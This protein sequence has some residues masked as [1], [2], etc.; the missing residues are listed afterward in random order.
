MYS[1]IKHKVND[2]A[3]PL[4]DRAAKS[5]KTN[6]NN[7]FPQEKKIKQKRLNKIDSWQFP[8]FSVLREE[9]L[10]IINQHAVI[11]RYKKKDFIYLP[12]DEGKDVYF[13]KRGAVEIGYLEE[14]GRELTLDILS[15]GE[16]FGS[17]FGMEFSDGYAR[18]LDDVELYVIGKN[19]FDDF[20]QE[21]SLLTYKLL[22]FLTLKI[23]ILKDRLQILVF[24]NVKTR[25]CKQLLALYRKSGDKKSGQIK[26]PLTHL[27]VAR[28]VGSTRETVSHL[29]AELKKEGIISY[30]KQY[31]SILSLSELA[32][33]MN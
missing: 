11:H 33:Q 31:I 15:S 10:D 28:L 3:L 29:M 13:I 21:H 27:D 30:K 6:Y 20:L 12:L 5:N 32:K 7:I 26:I 18:A 8:V 19:I 24:N 14:D 25:V 4:K 17:L 1:Q 2:S 16:I 23:D 22:K 9:E